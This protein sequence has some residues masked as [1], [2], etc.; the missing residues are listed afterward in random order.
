MQ[1]IETLYEEDKKQKKK[2]NN[3]EFL[4]LF[5][6]ILIIT[7]ICTIGL[8]KIN[9]KKEEPP[10]VEEKDV[11]PKDENQKTADEIEELLGNKNYTYKKYSCEKNGSSN[12]LDNKINIKNH[13]R[14]EFSFN[15]GIDDTVSLGYYYVDYIF[16]NLNDY[17]NTFSLPIY[18]ENKFYEEQENKNSLTKTQ[19]YYYILEYP[20]MNNGDFNTYLKNLENDGFVCTLVEKEQVINNYDDYYDSIEKKENFS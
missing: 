11:L 13:Y 3:K 2:K 20:N 16:Y 6:V 8:I 4:L 14:Y 18:F 7:I 17:N 19:M 15:E 5:M 12:V 10:N 1:Q 9:N